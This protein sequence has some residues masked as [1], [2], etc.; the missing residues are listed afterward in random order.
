MKILLSWLNDYV[1][2]GD[3]LDALADTLNELGLAVEDVIRTS[4]ACRASS[5]RASCA[6]SRHP[7]AAKVQRVWVDTGDGSERHVWCG[8]FNIAAGDVVPLATIGT[9]MPDGRDHRQRAASSASTPRGCCARRA[10]WASAT[11]TPASS[12]SRPTRPSACRTARR[13]ARATTSC[14]TSTSRAT[15]PTRWSLRRRR[16]RPRRQAATC[17]YAAGA[18]GARRR[19]RR[20]ARLTAGRDR[21]RRPLRPVHVDGAVRRRRRSERRRGWPAAAGG[22]HAT[23]QQRR[24]RQQLRDARAQPAEPRLRPG[25]ARRAAGS[26]SACARDGETMR[27]LDGTTRTLGARRPADLRRRRPADRHRRDHGRR[28]HR[29][30]PATTTVALEM[31]WFEPEPIGQT[32]AR[33]GLRSEASARFER[34]V[35]PYGDRYAPSPASSSCSAR[36]APTSSSHAGAVDERGAALPP[37]SARSTVRLAEVNRILGTSLGADDLPPL[38]DPIGFTVERRRRRRATVALAV[39]AAGQRPSEIDVIEEVARQYGYDRVGK[40]VPTSTLHGHLSRRPAAPPPAAPG[41]ARAWASPRRCRTRSSRRARL[42]RAGLD[43]D[44]L[45]DHQPA[46]RRGERCCARRCDPGCC[47]RSPST[48]RTGGTGVALFE[49]GHVYPPGPGELPDEYEALGVVLAG[50]EAP[51]AVAVW[52]E[53]ADGDGRRRAHRPGRVRRPGCTRPARRR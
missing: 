10:S 52:R 7:D 19:R 36:P 1:D 32:A 28:R 16:P 38:L 24:R 34:G 47:G 6:P 9:T 25:D 18:A 8:A 23:D 49:I 43:G 11:T 50:Q 45:R 13:S 42:R 12:C 53:L 30:H 51:A 41:A 4:A 37:G 17:R 5:R 46:R 22:G 33:L 40:R 26:A 3:D 39:V 20:P 27:T 44:A 21:R 2:I 31:A 29:D 48:S 15:A 14:S 35:D